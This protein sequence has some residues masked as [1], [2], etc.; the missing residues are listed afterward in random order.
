MN[1]MFPDLDPNKLLVAACPSSSIIPSSPASAAAALAAWAKPVEKLIFGS[2]AICNHGK[3][4]AALQVSPVGSSVHTHYYAPLSPRLMNFSILTRKDQ[5]VY[6][7][8]FTYL[9]SIQSLF[10]YTNFSP[11]HTKLLQVYDLPFPDH[12][13]DSIRIIQSESSTL[14]DQIHRIP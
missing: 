2:P 7:Q 13:F 6:N 10:Y 5:V 12:G 8:W 9:C 4:Q 1:P 3:P 14:R 11:S